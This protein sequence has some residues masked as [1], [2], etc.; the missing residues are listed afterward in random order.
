MYRELNFDDP[1]TMDDVKRLMRN[2]V[3]R[4]FYVGSAV[5]FLDKACK[6]D[7]FE[8]FMSKLDYSALG[9]EQEGVP[10]IFRGFSIKENLNYFWL[11]KEYG[12]ILTRVSIDT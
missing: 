1:R 3:G 7:V 12:L 11:L 5:S 6:G 9:R 2:F 10:E 8:A 4:Y